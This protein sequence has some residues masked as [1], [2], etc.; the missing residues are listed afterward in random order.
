MEIPCADELSSSGR[1]VSAP[2]VIEISFLVI[3]LVTQN[4]LRRSETELHAFL[5]KLRFQGDTECQLR[6]DEPLVPLTPSWLRTFHLP[7]PQ[8]SYTAP[9]PP[10]LSLSL[11]IKPTLPCNQ[12]LPNLKEKK[13]YNSVNRHRRGGSKSDGCIAGTGVIATET[14]S[15]LKTVAK[16]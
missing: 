9:S 2:S 11:P 12:T 8:S 10:P 7:T 13:S 6:H 16:V 15:N 5:T 1:S 3:P 4:S 14:P